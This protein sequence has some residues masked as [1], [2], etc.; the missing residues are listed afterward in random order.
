VE[1]T[2]F[3]EEKNGDSTSLAF[4]D[5]RPKAGEE[6]FDVLPSNVR[7]RW[8]RENCVK[9]SLMGALH[10]P[11]GTGIQY[12]AQRLRFLMPNVGAKRATTV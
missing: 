4:T 6:S 1:D 11:Y 8:V 9:C 5:F 7:A 12:R 3:V 2:H 10:S